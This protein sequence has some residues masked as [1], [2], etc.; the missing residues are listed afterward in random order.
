MTNDPVIIAVDAMGGDLGPSVI[1]Q[2]AVDAAMEAGVNVTLHNHWLGRGI[3]YGI[4]DIN[5]VLPAE[6]ESCFAL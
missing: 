2:G 6:K 3:I 1:V 4:R 5:C